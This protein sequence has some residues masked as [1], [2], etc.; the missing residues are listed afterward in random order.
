MLAA[1]MVI[2]H[3][4]P[5]AAQTGMSC[6]SIGT[7]TQEEIPPDRLPVPQKLSGIGNAHIQISASPEAQMW[8]DQGLNLLHDFWDYESVRAFEQSV[9]VDSQCAMCYWGIYR[10]AKTNYRTPNKYFRDQAL[11]KAVSLKS[12]ASK[13]ERLYIEASAAAEAAEKYEKKDKSPTASQ[14]AQL[15]RK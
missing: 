10:A 14:E 1:C 3:T 5:L 9:R 12:H 6:H 11:A 7:T 15:Y 4:Q 2:R 13:S 8:F